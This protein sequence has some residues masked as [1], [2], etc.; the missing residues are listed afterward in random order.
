[1]AFD[2]SALGQAGDAPLPFRQ[3]EDVFWV[4]NIGSV[5]GALG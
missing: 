4:D 5:R 2:G 1:M 3:R